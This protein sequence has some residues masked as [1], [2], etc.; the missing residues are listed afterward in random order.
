ML[1]TDPEEIGAFTDFFITDSFLIW[2]KIVA[3]FQGSD[4]WTYLKTSKKHCDGRLEFRIIYNDY[5]VPSNIDYMTAGAEKK[6][7]QCSYTGEKR[8]WTFE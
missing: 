7:D 3:I 2:D 8:N 1:E 4:A 6:L 5:L